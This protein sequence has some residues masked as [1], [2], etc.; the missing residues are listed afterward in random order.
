MQDQTGLEVVTRA[1]ISMAGQMDQIAISQRRLHVRNSGFCACQLSER[2]G[3]AKRMDVR[4][5]SACGNGTENG[6]PGSTSD[7]ATPSAERERSRCIW[8]QR[9]AQRRQKGE[10]EALDHRSSTIR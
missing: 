10:R 1:G 7:T 9:E 2:S 8:T 6:Q 3:P 5:A 4:S